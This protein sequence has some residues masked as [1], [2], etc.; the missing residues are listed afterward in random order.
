VLAVIRVPGDDDVAGTFLRKDLRCALEEQTVTAG[1]ET[2]DDTHG[3]PVAREGDHLNDLGRLASFLPILPTEVLGK[4]KKGGLGLGSYEGELFGLGV[5]VFRSSRVDRDGLVKQ[6]LQLRREDRVDVVLFDR[7]IVGVFAIHLELVGV[8]GILFL[9]LILLLIGCVRA[10]LVLLEVVD[11][12]GMD[13]DGAGDDAHDVLGERSGLVGA[14]NG[15]VCHRLTRTEDTNEE[16][17]LSHSFRGES[18]RKSHRK[19]EALWDSDDN[20]CYRD[21]GYACKGDALLISSTMK[22]GQSRNWGGG[23]KNTDQAGSPVPN[24]TKKRIMR[25]V[26]KIKPAAPPIFAMS[27]ARSFS[28]SCNGVESGSPRRAAKRSDVRKSG[29][30]FREHTHHDTA[31]ETLLTDSD[32]DV[33]SITFK[34]LGARNQEAI[35][36]GIGGVESMNVGTL[37]SCLFPEGNALF[38]ADLFDGVGLSCCAGLVAPDVVVGDEDTVAGDDLTGLEE[39]NTTNE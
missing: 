2:N 31:V 30:D 34:D 10:G 36:M 6:A 21:D 4:L 28:F 26:N 29:E 7:K 33:L 22:T 8:G 1:R 9:G 27:S 35:R 32:N 25:A 17:F 20:Q 38:V 5:D 12:F 14:D 3:F 39:G 16:I 15:G 19:R 18:E 24:W 23:R 11:E 13:A 37:A